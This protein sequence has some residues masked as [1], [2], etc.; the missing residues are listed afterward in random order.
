M[1]PSSSSTKKA[2]RLAQK[3]KG[4]KVRFQNGT[5]FPLIVALVVVLGSALVV[6]ARQSRPAADA[7]APTIDDH[8][9]HAYGFYICDTWITLEGDGEAQDA[10][11]RPTNVEYA[12]TGIHSHD[13]GLIHW[14]AFSS[15]SVGRN[16]TLGVFL[17]VYDV[18]LTNDVLQFPEDQRAQLPEEFQETGR[19]ET[20]ETE[21]TIDGE[22]ETGQLQV[23]RWDNLSDTDDGTTFIAG[24]DDI[25]LNKDAMVVSIAFVPD[26]TDVGKPPSVEGFD[27]NALN[28]QAQQTSTEL[29][30][31]VDVTPDGDVTVGTQ[32]IEQEDVGPAVSSAVES[33]STDAPTDEADS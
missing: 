1:A 5:L 16:A 30:P 9:H 4:Q 14:H 13:D 6:Y 27:E 33:Q 2:A 12:R 25:A 11:G 19:F 7:S 26:G 20:G 28:D 3:G 29:F 31:G 23:T 15:A 21:C 18:E 24:F 22:T 10:D 17:D 32:L 8:W